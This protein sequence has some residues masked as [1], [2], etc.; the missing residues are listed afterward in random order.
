MYAN[1]EAAAH[2]GHALGVLEAHPGLTKTEEVE[3]LLIRRAEAL[4]VLGQTDEAAALLGQAASLAK[5]RSDL[6][7]EAEAV[8]WL[9]RTHW[10]A[11]YP[12]RA[13]PHAEHA[14]DLAEKLRDE[15]LIGRA[16]GFL[17]NPHGSL[18]HLDEALEHAFRA[19]DI[20]E[21]L[22]EDPPAAVLYR[23][24]L[25]YHHRGQEGAALEALERGEAL[26]RDQHDEIILVFVHWV[27][28]MTLA[29]LGRFEE[30]FAALRAAESSGKGEEVF[31][32]SRVPNT[33]ASLYADLDLWEEARERDF[34][35]LDEIQSMGGIAASQEPRLQTLL[36]LAEDELMLGRTDAAERAVA[37][38]ERMVPY[39]EYGRFRYHNRLHYVRGLLALA[40]DDP[41]AASGAAAA[42]LDHAQGHGFPKY[43]VRGRLL[44]GRTLARLGETD[45][46]ERELIA[47]A[48]LAQALG[49][50]TWTRR[51]W[52]A[53]ADLT[54]SSRARRQAQIAARTVA[55]GLDTE[56][57]D[58]F[59]RTAAKRLR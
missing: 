34:A 19:R 3:R 59:M 10:A 29:N 41:E 36:N 15:R 53:L 21:S 5:G 35:A 58:R 54:D 20:F 2:Y 37:E 25:V 47:A 30:A 9:A 24:G 50:P 27:R 38:V 1:A 4:I 56:L 40:H 26:A 32:R 31:A 42:C 18:G 33:W 13:L 23:I 48:E 57:R 45:Q 16:H 49:Y 39:V 55:N 43:E 17:A 11:W 46:A 44:R 12:S 6:W 51:T 22:G 28:A 8:H 52:E 14:L 7:A